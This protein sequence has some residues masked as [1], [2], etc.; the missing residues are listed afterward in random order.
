D[1][2][3]LY[4]REPRVYFGERSPTYSIVGAPDG[5]RPQ[6]LDFPDESGTGQ[7]N[8]TYEG[9]GGVPVGSLF[10]RLLYAVKFQEGNILLSNFVNADSKILYE[11]EPRERIEKV[12]PWLTLDGD[13]Y[14]AVVEGRIVYIVDG[15]TTSNDYP[16]AA[17]RTLEETTVD[18]VTATSRTGTV[19]AQAPDEVN[20]IRNSV[21]ATVDAYDGTVTLYEWDQ[22]DPV[23][24]AWRKAF[25]DTVQD[26]EEI[27]DE[28]L[29]HLR[30]PEDLFKVQRE[31]LSRYHVT[32]PQ[33]YYGG[34]DFWKVPAD[35]TLPSGDQDQPPYYLTLQMPG[36]EQ[37]TF[38]LTSTFT[39]AARPQLS[40]FMAVNADPASGEDYGKMRVL[41]LPRNTTVPGPGQVQNQFDSDPEVSSQ[42]N[43]L[44]RGNSEVVSGNLLTI[45]VGDGL[46]YVEPV[47]V[48]AAG[49][50]SY[51]LLRKV[52]VG[53]GDRV[54]F[55]DTLQLALDD[56]F[57]GEAGTDTDETVPAPPPA[58][59]TPTPPPPDGSVDPTVQAALTEAQAA[60]VESDAALRAGDFAAYGV[61]QARLRAAIERALAAEAA[62]AGGTTPAPTETPNPGG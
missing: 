48:R 34:Q 39:P 62:A 54:A 5:S 49:G 31:L 32:D 13:P 36:Q 15:Y 29:Q 61:A 7:T 11:R 52:L 21:K 43:L 57:E 37:A 2:K 4:E 26:R 45:P 47:Y 60:L 20:Y 51:P 17:R 53:F 16:Y 18:S 41:R 56:I 33:A 44:R 1:S 59:G 55:A 10:N 40:A 50:E 27:S 23:L 38:S 28:L 19:V 25:P 30:Y 58:E 12:A 14:P 6:E 8:N 46:L 24:K 42:L 35:P 9:E 22:S 3:I